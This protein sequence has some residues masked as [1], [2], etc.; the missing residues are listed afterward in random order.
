MAAIEPQSCLWKSNL[1][2]SMLFCCGALTVYLRGGDD[3]HLYGLQAQQ[4]LQQIF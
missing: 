4:E 3:D 1:Y 2:A